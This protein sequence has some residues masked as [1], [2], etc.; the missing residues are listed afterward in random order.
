MDTSTYLL[1][2]NEVR[3][4]SIIIDPSNVKPGTSPLT[5]NA[6]DEASF[7]LLVGSINSANVHYATDHFEQPVRAVHLVVF[8]GHVQQLIPGK[9]N[10]ET[11]Y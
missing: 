10:I 1:C 2:L 3:H 4:M 11:R 8:E 9:F 6:R 5:T 7:R